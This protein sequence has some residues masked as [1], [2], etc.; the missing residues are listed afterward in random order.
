M[1]Y[2]TAVLSALVMVYGSG[3]RLVDEKAPCSVVMLVYMMDW[4][5]DE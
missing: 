2:Q 1:V 4:Q 5:L 3:V